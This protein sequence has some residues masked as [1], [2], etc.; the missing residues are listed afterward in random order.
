MNTL[1][2]SKTSLHPPAHRATL[3]TAG[4]RPVRLWVPDTRR[5]GF[6]EE[7]QRQCIL[8]AQADRTDADIQRLMDA[9]L[10]DVEGWTA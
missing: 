9:A 3:R 1:A 6:A 10:A 2:L 7:C 5:A 4:L 8:A